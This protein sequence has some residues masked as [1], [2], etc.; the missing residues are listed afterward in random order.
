MKAHTP[1]NKLWIVDDDAITRMLIRRKLGKHELCEE[2]TEFA[3]GQPAWEAL[4]ALGEKED[5]SAL[6][7]LIL[8]DINMP[9]MGAWEFLDRLGQHPFAKRLAVA[10]ISS[11]IDWQDLQKSKEYSSVC[12]YLAKPLSIDELT[13]L[14]P[15]QA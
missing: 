15:F 7:S 13:A 6:P 4:T 3:D 10:I 8:L 14:K 2:I 9:V 12:G 1:I 11:S 5:W